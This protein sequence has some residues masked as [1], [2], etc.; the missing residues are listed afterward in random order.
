MRKHMTFVVAL[1]AA[2]LTAAPAYADPVSGLIALGAA[3]GS[4]LS[5]SAILSFAVKLALSVAL[6]FGMQLLSGK[7]KPK[8]GNQGIERPG[9][10]ISQKESVSPRRLVYGKTR[11]GGTI[12]FLSSHQSNSWLYFTIAL[13]EGPV[14]DVEGIYLNDDRP[15]WS[16]NDFL[17]GG[18]AGFGRAYRQTGIAGTD[19]PPSFFTT[20]TDGLWTDDHKLQGVAALFCA[21]E[22]DSD[23]TYKDGLP[24]VSALVKGLKVYDPRSGLTA[25]TQNAALIIRDYLLRPKELGGVGLDTAE[26]DDANFIAQANI[27]DEVV[28]TN[29]GSVFRYTINGII[30]L[31]E[32]TSPGDVLDEMLSACQGR[33][34]WTSGQMRLFVGAWRASTF[35]ITADMIVDAPSI[36][37]RQSMASQFNAVK[38]TYR[39]VDA[40][41]ETTDFK[42]I[43][44][45]TFE[46]EDGGD[47]VYRDLTFNFVV[48][49]ATAQRLAKMELYRAREPIEVTL[50]CNML[51]YEVA[52]GD[53]I[54]VTLDRYGW[55]NK[56]F[57]VTGWKWSIDDKDQSQALGVTLT[58]RESSAAAYSWTA[59]EEDLLE[60]APATNLPDW[61]NPGAPSN[62][63]VL[64]E[65][66]ETSGSAGVKS[67][68]TLFWDPS[69]DGFVDT[70]ELQYK[71][72]SSS[73]WLNLP[74]ATS[75]SSV[76]P[77]LAA[78]TYNFRVRSVNVLKAKSAYVQT[79]QV[80]TG[81]SAP[82]ADPTGVRVEVI[83]GI[84]RLTWD[85]TVSLDVKIGGSVLINHTPQTSSIA[86]ANSVQV[87]D[88]PGDATSE[89]LP[90]QAGTYIVRFRDSSGVLSTGFATVAADQST[91]VPYVSIASLTESPTFTGTKTNCATDGTGL[92]ITTTS[93]PATYLFSTYLDLGSIRT[94]RLTTVCE[95][96]SFSSSDLWDSRTGNIDTWTEIDG[97]TGGGIDAVVWARATND[98]PASSP[99]WGAWFRIT[100]T[101]IKARAFQFKLEFAA[102]DPT[103]N[104][105]V[106][107][108]SAKAE[109]P[110]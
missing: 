56:T 94:A 53:V 36:T 30:E 40:R 89:T 88:L 20:R 1:C 16:G 72:S 22:W 78:G 34:A 43:T 57:E 35:E 99:T 9:T 107:T 19:V 59:T 60:A 79:T 86:W 84:A 68:A 49:N 17:N 83:G 21:F 27:C 105:R 31:D 18:Y 96:I 6:S 15:Q 7:K 103:W 32:S 109:E 28:N 52:V 82:P 5:G 12:V 13:C 48:D 75:T 29:G 69:A 47:R 80:I 46:A 73:T 10:N 26:I 4:A 101:D 77:D 54:G 33:I 87:A 65:L 63:S 39:S 92:S 74:N 14:E 8:P 38:G 66:Y 11:L 91:A 64:E 50:P 100:A 45:A 24:N 93:S 106:L 95:V 42:A 108:L 104:V 37:T 3:L 23:G 62:L 67:R 98:N 61:N 44:S 97:A 102:D 2:L 51:A 25:F 71:L 76:L 81:L 90:A 85:R 58:L 41:Y 110:A 70:Y 55:D